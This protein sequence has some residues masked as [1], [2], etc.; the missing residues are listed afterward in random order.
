MASIARAN[1]ALKKVLMVAR[2][3]PPFQS[4]GHSIRVAKFTKYLPSL[5]WLP[6]VLT[7]DDRHEYESDRRQGSD[8]LLSEISSQVQIVRTHAGEPSLEFLSKEEAFGRRNRWTRACAKL[9]GGAR[10]WSF[11]NLLIPD[12]SLLWL[13]FAVWQGRQLVAQENIDVIFA[14]CPPHSTSL[15][16]VLLKV[17]TG[18]QLVLDF[19]DDWIDTPWYHSRAAVVRWVHRRMERWAVSHADRVVLVTAWSQRAFVRRYPVQPADKFVLISNGCDLEDFR[20]V[21]ERPPP[22]KRDSFTVVHAGAMNDSKFWGRD[23][24]GLFQGVLKLVRR[25]PAVADKL[26]I[27]FAGGLTEKQQERADAMGLSDIIRGIG[28]LPH[29]KV[30]R[31]MQSADL[32]LAINYDNWSTI[33]PAKLYEYWAIG[34]PPIMLL[35][36]PGAAADFVAEHKLGVTVDPTDSERIQQALLSF[37]RQAA[38]ASPVRINTDGIEAY[39]R[40]TLSQA[41]AQ[42]LSAVT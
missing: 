21:A 33:I 1:G 17:L 39:D 19:R 16:G 40:R 31:L 9:V 20:W 35:S 14:T 13:P 10:R 41:L 7:I 32:L 6:S 23:P 38:L 12:R 28:H 24:E 34:G 5:G 37:S 4:M 2:V 30:L 3:F 27:L 29:D 25:E 26:Q 8:S 11:R 42:V 18:K 15:V 22:E 36:C